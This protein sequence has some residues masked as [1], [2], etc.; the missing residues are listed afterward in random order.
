MNENT[1]KMALASNEES[2]DRRLK[3]IFNDHFNKAKI[4]SSLK[5]NIS[6]VAMSKLVLNYPINK[7][8]SEFSITG[9]IYDFVNQTYNSTKEYWFP[10]P[11][12]CQM[13]FS[14]H[15]ELYKIVRRNF[16]GDLS[17]PEGY[18]LRS[19]M[20]LDLSVGDWKELE[21]SLEIFLLIFDTYRD[22]FMDKS[23]H[24]DIFRGFLDNNKLAI[25]AGLKKLE[26]SKLR[27][28]RQKSVSEEKHISIYT[29]AI[30]KLAWMHGM[31]VRIES[32]YVPKKLLPF[33]PLEEYTIPYK[34]LRDFYREQGIDWRYDP[35]H[36]ELQDWGNDP[37]NPDR[38][39]G[40]FF[41]TLFG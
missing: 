32:E 41:K 16:R 35:I 15:K 31:E 2:I 5:S 40:G 21:K 9:I 37:E 25:E 34:F 12:L 11:I 14:D 26:T 27:K 30:A 20:F 18:Y 13:F 4:I 29:T 19:K 1:V 6:S 36:P 24:L 33:E 8:K 3:M 23:I 10:L 38:K 28:I 39:K 17:H 22:D 7:V